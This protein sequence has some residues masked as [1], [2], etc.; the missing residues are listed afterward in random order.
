MSSSITL[1]AEEALRVSRLGAEK[2]A[3]LF[4]RS[5]MTSSLVRQE[6]Q[7]Y[8][9]NLIAGLLLSSLRQEGSK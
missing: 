6:V 8:M 4:T 1:S 3:Q 7:A 2:A 5:D 9:D